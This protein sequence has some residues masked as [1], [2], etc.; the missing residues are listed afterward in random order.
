MKR[1]CAVA[2]MLMI[3]MT[4]AFS[5][6]AYSNEMA[7][8]AEMLDQS[9]DDDGT[10]VTYDGDNIIVSFPASFFS[11]NEREMFA[12]M[13]SLQPLAP[14]LKKYIVESTG[15]ETIAMLGTIFMQFDTDLVVRLDTGGVTKDIVITGA[16]L[17]DS[18][19]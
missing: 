16:Q 4:G 12:G 7:E 5:A 11:D 13:D 9:I 17:L 18:D 8:L 6:S 10:S 2:I 15:A 1:I 19:F 3:V 14:E